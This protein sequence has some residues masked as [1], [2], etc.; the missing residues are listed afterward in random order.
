METKSRKNRGPREI[1]KTITLLSESEEVLDRQYC[2][3]I[4]LLNKI[5]D[6]RNIDKNQFMVHGVVSKCW[7]DTG[8]S[9]SL[10]TEHVKYQSHY[11]SKD[12]LDLLRV[13]ESYAFPEHIQE[14]KSVNSIKLPN[15]RVF[16]SGKKVMY[17]EYLPSE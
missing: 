16:I 8:P 11:F 14:K 2:T 10:T 4:S 6:L 12:S 15:G 5:Y 9:D 17:E 1:G 7:D 3:V 13:D